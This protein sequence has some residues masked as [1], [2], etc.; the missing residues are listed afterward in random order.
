M[1]WVNPINPRLRAL[2]VSSYI[3][4]PTATAMM[5]D[6]SVVATRENQNS[7]NDR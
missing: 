2:L 5:F 1:N 3:C 7:R 4:Q 6:A